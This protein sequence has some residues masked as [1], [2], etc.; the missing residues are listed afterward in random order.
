MFGC[1][2]NNPPNLWREMNYWIASNQML[3]FCTVPRGAIV[4]SSTPLLTLSSLFLF[5]FLLPVSQLPC[6][7]AAG[8]SPSSPGRLLQWISAVMV[9]LQHPLHQ[10]TALF[11][12]V[13]FFFSPTQH[14]LWNHHPTASCRISLLQRARAS[15]IL[16]L[17]PKDFQTIHILRP[18]ISTFKILLV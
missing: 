13:Y 16:Y 3:S 8:R 14:P 7:V 2:S 1:S 6:P 4:I 11:F 9:R 5:L 18:S 10:S 17:L 15:L 12:L